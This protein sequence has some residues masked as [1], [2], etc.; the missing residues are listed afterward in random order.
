MLFKV[1]K[2]YS[3][4]GATPVAAFHEEKDAKLFIEAKLAEDATMNIKVIYGLLEGM[5][6]LQEYDPDKLGSATPGTQSAS[7]A[8][9]RISPFSTTLKPP[10]AHKWQTDKDEKK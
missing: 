7:S 8:S 1:T 3:K 2:R 9:P 6:V 4:G 10:G 5:D